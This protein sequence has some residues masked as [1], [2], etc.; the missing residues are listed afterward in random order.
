MRHV[1]QGLFIIQWGRATVFWTFLNPAVF[2]GPKLPG[3]FAKLFIPSPPSVQETSF[4][5]PI[6]FE[7][8]SFWV[9][10]RGELGLSR[11]RWSITKCLLL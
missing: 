6:N 10:Q 2:A 8:T 4:R 11:P 7:I 5:D 1:K 9:L 3:Q